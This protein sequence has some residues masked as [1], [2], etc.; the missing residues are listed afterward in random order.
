MNAHIEYMNQ[1]YETYNEVYNKLDNLIILAKNNVIKYDNLL[2]FCSKINEI[3]NKLSNEMN[4]MKPS[5]YNINN[6]NNESASYNLFKKFEE[7]SNKLTSKIISTKLESR[8]DY[9][10]T[11]S[12]LCKKF[13]EIE[14]IFNCESYERKYFDLVPKK[15]DEIC[16]FFFNTLIKWTFKDIQDLTERF[17]KKK[18]MPFEQKVFD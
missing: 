13:K 7:I 5:N 15:K 18:I 11:V 16:A 1:K 17:L 14:I 3:Q 10:T 12:K 9:F 8:K 2:K 4:G 6:L